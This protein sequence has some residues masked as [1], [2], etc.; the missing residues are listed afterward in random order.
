VTELQAL[1]IGYGL[2]VL[3]IGAE[4]LLSWVRRDG[5]YRMGEFM[6]NIG[7]GAVFQVFDGFTKFL[8]LAPFMAIATLSVVTLPVD[9]VWGWVVGLL[10]YD[11][12]SYWQHRH[13]HRIHALWAIH[14]VHHAAEDFNF[15]AALRQA[16]FQNVTSWIWKAPLALV[17]PLEM[18]VGLVVFD[19]VYQFVQHTRYVPRLGPLEWV[20]NTPSHHRVHHGRQPKYIDKNYG[21][22]LI[23]WDRL[24]GTFQV[25]EEE[26]DYGITMPLNSLNPVWG[27]FALWQDL[28]RASSKT[29]GIW[30]KAR[31]WLGPPEWT[32]QL[33]GPVEPRLS[34]PIENAALPEARKRYVGLSYLGLPPLLAALAW[35]P[36]DAWGLRLG[37][38]ALSV[39]SAVTPGAL[40]EER[41]WARAAE[42]VRIAC[43]GGLAGTMAVSGDAP[44]AL[45]AVVL[46]LAVS[47]LAALAAGLPSPQPRGRQA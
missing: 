20:F 47:G 7:H 34:A 28:A 25:E 21:G 5:R 33:A 29:T 43:A 23:I 41:P 9:T 13:H 3:L 1:S 38:S 44:I 10:I 2:F 36:E 39:L 42:G 22:I 12:A 40:I 4:L 35:I 27:N 17:L 18:F 16:L 26:P 11:F 15:A 31:L 19:Y 37:V 8:V 32:E 46:A 14:G 30:N 45:A 24:L 6:V